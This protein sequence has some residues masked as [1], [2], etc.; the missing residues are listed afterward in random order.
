MSGKLEGFRIDEVDICRR[1]GE[2]YAVGLSNIFRDE[3]PRLFLDI[4]WLISNRH[5]DECFSS[6]TLGEKNLY[7]QP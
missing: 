5:L 2:D 1:N 7:N 3:I 6:S 4:R